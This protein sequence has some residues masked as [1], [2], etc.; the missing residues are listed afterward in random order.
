[1]AWGR[2]PPTNPPQ[3][4]TW[5]Y[6][7]A[8]WTGT[9]IKTGPEGTPTAGLRGIFRPPIPGQK[10]GALIG[11][12][13]S[14]PAI[15]TERKEFFYIGNGRTVTFPRGGSLFLL[16]NDGNLENNRGFFQV[17]FTR[18]TDFLLSQEQRCLADGLAP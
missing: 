4:I 17:E 16:V 15:G 7:G 1:M 10:Y 12:I 5:G 2:V 11:L 14:N 13:V 3:E 18:C 6:R 8:D 9:P